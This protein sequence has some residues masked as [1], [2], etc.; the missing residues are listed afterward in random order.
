VK[1]QRGWPDRRGMGSESD[2]ISEQFVPSERYKVQQLAMAGTL[3]AAG[4]TQEQID[5]MFPVQMG[6]PS[7][8][9]PKGR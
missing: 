3:I 6:V 5:A 9:K 2:A 4:F 7:I 1:K 8:E